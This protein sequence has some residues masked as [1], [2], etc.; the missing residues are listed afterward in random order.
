MSAIGPLSGATVVDLTRVLAGPYCTMVLADLG[1]RVIKVEVPGRGDDAR[2]F[3]PFINGQSAYFASLNRGKHSIALDLKAEHDRR[4]F[5]GLLT[6]ADVLVENYRPG[7]MD[8]LGYGWS[9]LHASY[10]DLIYATTSGFGQSGPYKDRAAYDMVVQ[11]MGGLLSLTGHPGGPPTRVGTSIGDITAALFTAVG[12][13]AALYSRQLRGEGMLVDVSMLDCQVAILENAIARY[14]ATGNVPGPLGSRHPSIAPFDAY[15][16]GD[17]FIIITA[18]ND[19]LF[20]KLADAIG[21]PELAKNH[22][23][24]SNTR[25]VENVDLLKHELES[26]LAKHATAHWLEVLQSAGVPCGP[27]NNVEQVVND[28]QVQG[29]N[30]VIDISDSEIGSLRAAGN[31]IKFSAFPDPPNRAPAPRLDADRAEI[32]KELTDNFK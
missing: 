25:R 4:T 32:L 12:I 2:H 15:K 19:D 9:A 16:T 24:A 21:L 14:F 20:E 5:E 3:G 26:A 29:R 10:P 27:I 7:T 30:M 18:G 28:Q 11:G 22:R 13:N 6:D 8:R 17:G 1:A 23:F 31:P